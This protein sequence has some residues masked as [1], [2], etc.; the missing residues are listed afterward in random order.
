TLDEA[1]SGAAVIDDLRKQLRGITE[2]Q[3]QLDEAAAAV[4][5]ARQRARRAASA[6]QR[7]EEQ[8]GTAWRAFDASRDGLA[9]LAPPPPADRS[10]LAAA[11][12]ALSEWAATTAAARVSER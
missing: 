3:L 1:L 12:A 4:S 9:T 10:D 2:L 7:A 6:A 8:I 11:W 5:E